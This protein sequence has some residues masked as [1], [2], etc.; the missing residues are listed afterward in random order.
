MKHSRDTATKLSQGVAHLLK[1]NKV[2]VI[3]GHAKLAGQGKLAVEKDG[4]QVQDVEA[5]HIILAPGARAR[6]LPHIEADGE[7][8]WTYREAMVP[9]EM[10]KKILVIGSGAIGME[11]ASFYHDM[12]VDV[13]VAEVVDR[14]LPAEDR[15]ISDFARKT[16][17]KKGIKIHTEA[18]VE[19]VEKGKN[20]ATATLKTKDGQTQQLEV[21]KVVLSVGIVANTENLGLDG[22]KVETERRTSKPTNGC[23]PASP[24]SM[25]SAMPPARRGWRTRRAT[26]A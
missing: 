18:N 9:K 3:D 2:T 8:V 11:F 19:Q 24:A 26:R 7:T 4:K 23:A 16:F 25:R 22:T 17:E 1:K 15:E 20:G 14:I 5:K 6:Q 12:G 10:P 13:T 21:D